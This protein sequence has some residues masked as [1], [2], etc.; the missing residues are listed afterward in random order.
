MMIPS[1]GGE[2]NAERESRRERGTKN[3]RVEGAKNKRKLIE[4]KM[5]PKVHVSRWNYAF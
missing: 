2:R 3:E 5:W 1:G 4:Y